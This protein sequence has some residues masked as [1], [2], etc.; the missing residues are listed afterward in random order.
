M[1]RIETIVQEFT[2]YHCKEKTVNELK[3]GEFLINSWV[4]NTKTTLTNLD[5]LHAIIIGKCDISWLCR[6][7]C[8]GAQNTNPHDHLS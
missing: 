4:K 1:N 2:Q 6:A 3:D 8:R 7:C 5:N